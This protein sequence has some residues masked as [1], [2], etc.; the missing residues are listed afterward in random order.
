MKKKLLPVVILLAVAVVLIPLYMIFLAPG[1]TNGQ[2]VNY[3]GQKGTHG[4]KLTSNGRPYIIDIDQSGINSL[5]VTNQNGSFEFYRGSDGE[6][7]LRGA[8]KYLYDMNKQKQLFINA[9]TQ[10]I[11]IEKYEEYDSLETYG[12]TAD[13][14]LATAEITAQDGGYYKIIFGDKLATNGAYYAML[15]GR[16]AVYALDT[17]LEST[18][19]CTAGDFI[20]PLLAPTVENGDYSLISAL[21]IKK[22]GEPFVEV[23]KM[24]PEE[25][26]ESLIFGQ[27]KMTYPADF[28]PSADNLSGVL[29]AVAE[30]SADR[31]ADYNIDGEKLDF[32]GFKTGTKYE[33]TY[34]CKDVDYSLYFSGKTPRNTYYVYSPAY[35]LIG[36]ISADRVDF[37]EWD[38]IRYVERNIFMVNIDSIASVEITHS[39]TTDTF[40]LTSEG[41]SLEVKHNKR[42]TDTTNF[43]YFYKSLLSICI[44]G[45]DTM[46]EGAE[47]DIT[48]TITSRSGKVL[49]YKFYYTSSL[50]AFFTLNGKGEFYVNRDYLRTVISNLTKLKNGEKIEE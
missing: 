5:K 8:E 39:G 26:E 18:L 3:E 25:E 40:T 43:R 35:D 30:F 48:L 28:S 11:A 32:Y 1:E 2:N 46:P 29:Y 9:A 45:Y 7:Y 42:I 22:N 23:V 49:E 50:R 15:E 37:L 27:Y 14:C 20:M 13:T 17:M 24:T 47:S 34:T 10:L 38:I 41:D 16:E 21:S 6:M 44:D 19:F 4:E 12:L 33:I 31:I 36:E